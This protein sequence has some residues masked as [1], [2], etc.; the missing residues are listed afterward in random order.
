M[1]YASAARRWLTCAI[2][3]SAG[4]LKP[5]GDCAH[6]LPNRHGE[7]PAGSSPLKFRPCHSALTRPPRRPFWPGR[8]L[9][10]KQGLCV[11]PQLP[12]ITAQPSNARHSPCRSSTQKQQRLLQSRRRRGEGSTMTASI[13]R[14]ATDRPMPQPR[15]PRQTPATFPTRASPSGA[16]Q[17]AAALAAGAEAG[18]H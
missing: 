15:A 17:E 5:G 11:N 8:M 13:P 10:C 3:A 9:S 14:R 4:C 1:S 7:G 2:E 12:A 18:A 6:E 16:L